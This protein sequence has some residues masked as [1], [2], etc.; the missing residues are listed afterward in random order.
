MGNAR[1]T[2]RPGPTW[3]TPEGSYCTDGDSGCKNA[4]NQYKLWVWKTGRYAACAANGACGYEDYV[5]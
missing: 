4:D 1:D 5:R 3:T 2:G